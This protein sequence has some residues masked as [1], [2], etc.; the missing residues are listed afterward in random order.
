MTLYHACQIPLS[1]ISGKLSHA[2]FIRDIEQG[3]YA[4]FLSACEFDVD[5]KVHPM[6]EQGV[7]ETLLTQY[8]RNNEIDLVVMGTHGRSGVMSV[9]LGSSGGQAAQLA[10]LRCA[11]SSRTARNPISRAPSRPCAI[12]RGCVQWPLAAGRNVPGYGSSYPWRAFS[13]P[14]KT[15][16]I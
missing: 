14:K 13:S 11:R 7:L 1:G 6:I 4:D 8:V 15:V 2:N 3:E 5:V 16:P 12:I 10:A 9:L